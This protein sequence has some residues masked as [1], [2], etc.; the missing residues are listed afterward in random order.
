[1]N[2]DIAFNDDGIQVY[3]SG[4][5]DRLPDFMSAIMEGVLPATV[6]SFEFDAA[7]SVLQRDLQMASKVNETVKTVSS[8]V[9]DFFESVTNS[10]LLIAGSIARSAADRLA[11]NISGQLEAL[12]KLRESQSK[13]RDEFR[14]GLRRWK[15]YL[16]DPPIDGLRKVLALIVLKEN[17][18]ALD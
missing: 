14:D 5:A 17:P 2:F 7:R 15:E 18:R 1:M 16:K 12:P 8:D 6:G 4:Y 3:A 9:R 10:D 11:D 13:Q